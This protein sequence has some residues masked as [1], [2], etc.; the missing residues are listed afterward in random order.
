MAVTQRKGIVWRDAKTSRAR[1]D[2]SLV[3]VPLLSDARSAV[4]SASAKIVGSK[5]TAVSFVNSAARQD[6]AEAINQRVR[7]GDL[8]AVRLAL[9]DFLRDVVAP[10]VSA[11]VE[12]AAYFR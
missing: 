11:A 2:A 4:S 5:T 12:G 7:D 8:T 1:V 3:L 10:A 9:R 6:A